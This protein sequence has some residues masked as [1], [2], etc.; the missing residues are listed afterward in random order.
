M[1]LRDSKNTESADSKNSQVARICGDCESGN[2]SGRSIL[3]EK[4]EFFRSASLHITA[5][6]NKARRGSLL[7]INEQ[8]K[9]EAIHAL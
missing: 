1:I 6:K 3:D 4:S 7:A 9:A 8:S 2:P 5:S